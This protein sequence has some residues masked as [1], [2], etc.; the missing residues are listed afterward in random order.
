MPRR[1]DPLDPPP[2]PL[3]R[4][5]PVCL[6]GPSAG[7]RYAPLTSAQHHFVRGFDYELR[8][9]LSQ[10]A[11]LGGGPDVLA[12]NNYGAGQHLLEKIRERL[13]DVQ[14]ANLRT[15]LDEVAEK[16]SKRFERWWQSYRRS[17]AGWCTRPTQ[18]PS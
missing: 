16:W 10:Y 7:H 13:L 3:Q 8:R 9:A 12:P 5:L 14:P 6:R 11:P 1:P 18:G 17:R 15:R 2:D 4:L